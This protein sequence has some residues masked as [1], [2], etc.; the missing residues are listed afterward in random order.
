[1]AHQPPTRIICPLKRLPRPKSCCLTW[2]K[3]FPAL[4]ERA[5]MRDSNHEQETCLDNLAAEL[6]TAV[7]PVA[8]RHGIGG[9]WVDLELDLW[10]ALS[11]TVRQRR[12]K[13]RLVLAQ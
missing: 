11:E 1:M 13:G 4:I 2:R 5:Y 7:Y 6:T 8:L 10:K 9:S 3:M 12:R